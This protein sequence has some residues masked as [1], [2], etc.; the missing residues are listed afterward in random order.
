MWTSLRTV[1]ALSSTAALLLLCS[2]GGAPDGSSS[3]PGASGASGASGNEATGTT[4]EALGSF[5][6]ANYYALGGGTIKVTYSETSYLGVPVLVYSDGTRQLTFT[7][8][9][10]QA[11]STS[12]GLLVSATTEQIIGV[13]AQSFS[14][15]IPRVDVLTNG[16]GPVQ[17]QGITTWHRYL[18]LTSTGEQMDVYTVTPVSG[19]ASQ[20]FL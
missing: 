4:S 7:G 11:Q 16:S 9:Q 2:C 14:V 10:F 5:A 17:T 19:T 13:G 8:S 1:A 20:L 12:A 3:A 18:D 6:A 15:L